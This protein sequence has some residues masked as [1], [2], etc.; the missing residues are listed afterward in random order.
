MRDPLLYVEDILEAIEKIKRYTEGMEFEDFEDEKTVDAVI[1]NLEIIGEA[2]K[3]LPEEF[4]EMHPDVP[5][6]EIAGMRDRLI[7]AYF[8]V[9]LSIVWY[10]IKNDLD[11]IEFRLK[12][13]LEGQR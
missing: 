4:K 1:C 5:W 10:T 8:G 2:V 7:H 3:N 6:K 11:D 12:S 9:D 13:I